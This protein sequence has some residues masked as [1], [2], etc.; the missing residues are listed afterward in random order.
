MKQT[1]K[2]RIVT[3]MSQLEGIQEWFYAKHFMPPTMH[4]RDKLVVGYSAS[5]RM[6]EIYKECPLVF[7]IKQDGKFRA[8][9]INFKYAREHFKDI[10]ATI[11]FWIRKALSKGYQIRM[12]QVYYEEKEK[13]MA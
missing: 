3:R 4:M 13:D 9:K 2:S 7:P 5:S 11:P 1:Y 6:T 10:P 8:M 12:N